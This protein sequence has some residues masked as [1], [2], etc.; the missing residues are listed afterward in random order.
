MHKNLDVWKK[1]MDLAE[2][3]YMET[4]NFPSEEKFGLVSQ[5]RRSVVS[6]P[7]NIAEGFARETTKELIHFLRIALGSAAEVETQVLLAQRIGYLSSG[8]IKLLEGVRGSKKLL[9][10]LIKSLKRRQKTN[11]K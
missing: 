9:I 10:G 8:E 5:L 6:I 7:S 1:S 2:E 4:N 3:V 11:G